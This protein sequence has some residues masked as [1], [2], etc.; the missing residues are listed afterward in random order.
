[1]G[2]WGTG[3]SSNDTF[4]EVYEAFFHYYNRNHSIDD[5]KSKLSA[6]FASTIEDEYAS[7]DYWFGLAKALWECKALDKDTFNEVANIIK[8]GKNLKVWKAL[9][10]TE[11][12]LKKRAI[13]LHKFL[14]KISTE[15]PKARKRKKII[16][17]TGHYPKGTCL[18]F[19]MSNG[20]YGGLLVLEQ[21]K[22]TLE[23]ENFVAALN[24]NQKEKPTPEDFLNAKI[25]TGR[26]DDKIG[27]TIYKREYFWVFNFEGK[28]KR[29]NKEVEKAF[30]NVGKIEIG[31]TFE[32]DF[33]KP[34]FYY[35][36]WISVV[37]VI[38]NAIQ[39]I[40]GGEKENIE[41]NVKDW[42]K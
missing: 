30:I 32:S 19:K 10:A 2:H 34:L 24:I 12:D 31:R 22:E 37:K 29:Y 5:I 39:K 15:K 7:D 35:D 33:S 28:R 8:S 13:V 23:G 3:I 18:T 26:H 14:E 25:L 20:H 41:A 38:E 42:I 6:H 27:D 4:M 16:L 9:D 1:M 40:E 17:Y 21:K 36:K 11:S